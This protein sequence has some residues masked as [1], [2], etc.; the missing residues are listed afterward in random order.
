MLILP[1]K[2]CATDGESSA[3]A[4]AGCLVNFSDFTDCRKIAVAIK[5]KQVA[6]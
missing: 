6:V 2:A 5:C 4:L 3:A 1:A